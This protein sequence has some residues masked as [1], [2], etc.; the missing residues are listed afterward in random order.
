MHTHLH[1][2]MHAHIHA[3]IFLNLF[4]T[5]VCAKAHMCGGQRMTI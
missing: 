2:H 3:Y 5:C 4:I 1:T